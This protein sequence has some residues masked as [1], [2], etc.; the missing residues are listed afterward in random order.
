MTDK[1]YRNELEKS[2]YNAQKMLFDEYINYVYAI[3]F[4]L[5][6]GVAEREDIDEC[7]SDTFSDIFSGYDKNSAFDGEMKGFIAIIA[8][9]NAANYYK[10]LSSKGITSPLEELNAAPDTTDLSREFEKAEIRRLLIQKTLEL[11]EPDSTIVFQKYFCG[12][13]SKEIAK[14]VSL[15]PSAV[16]MRCTRAVRRLKE[17]LSEAGIG[18]EDI[19]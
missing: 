19:Q 15:K 10:R 13:N 3:V 14:I 11:G 4:S 9:R 18:E 2:E 16:R 5:L 7:V 6:R 17:M 12:R 1:D 8:R